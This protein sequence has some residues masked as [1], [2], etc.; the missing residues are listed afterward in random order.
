MD[1]LPRWWQPLLPRVVCWIAW[2]L[3]QIHADIVEQAQAS[4]VAVVFQSDRLSGAVGKCKAHA[5]IGL[6][7]AAASIEFHIAR[8]D[9][10]STRLYLL[11]MVSQTHGI[12]CAQEIDLHIAAT[13]DRF[14]IAPIPTALRV[15]DIVP[16]TMLP[17]DRNLN[18][19]K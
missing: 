1:L 17:E 6:G 2:E 12:S 19:F 14:V 8:R 7:N 13:R 3:N 9:M 5:L 4:F 10:S 11:R 16:I 15:N 18:I